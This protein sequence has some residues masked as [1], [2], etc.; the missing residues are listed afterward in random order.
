MPADHTSAMEWS[1]ECSLRLSIIA[2]NFGDVGSAMSAWT[3]RRE[4]GI[5]EER[6]KGVQDVPM[7]IQLGDTS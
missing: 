5:W 4:G 6:G 2:G 3:E 1:S 7:F